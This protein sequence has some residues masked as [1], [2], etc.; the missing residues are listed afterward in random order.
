[1][2]LWLPRWPID[3]RRHTL[4][5]RRDKPGP[6]VLAA[7]VGN[8][9]LVTAVNAAAEALGIAPGL[10]LA[11]AR[12]LHPALAVA[13][14]DPAGD[15][16]ALARLALWCGRYS[17]WTAPHG[18]DGVWLDVTG[19]AHLQGGEESLAAELVERLGRQGIAGRAAIAD[20]AGAA[21]AVA[22]CGSAPAVVV[23]E[24]GM[25]AA[26]A[27][28]PVLAL[29]LDPALAGELER[30]GLRRIGDLY[31]LPR[32]ALVTR[33][34][35]QVTRRLDQALGAVP[36]PLSPLPP[37][38]ARWTRRRFAEPIG[39][40]EAIAAATRALLEALCRRL[41]DEG[42]GLR[43][44]K[45]KLYRVDGS[46][47]EAAIGTARPSR[48]VRH[49]LRLIEEKL[50]AID[51]GL[52]IEDML[53]EAAK[54]ETLAAA[55]LSFRNA[56][57]PFTVIPAKAGTQGNRTSLALGPRFRG[58]DGRK[59]RGEERGY[60]R[61]DETEIAALVDRLA[62][63]LGPGAVF[64][65]LPRESHVPERAVRRAPVFTTTKAAPWD[66]QRLRP[67][68]LLPRPEPIEAVA[69]I[70]DD[71]PILFRWR[72]LQH[73][74]RRA[75]GPERILGEWWRSAEEAEELRDYYR[76]E[77]EAG[78]RFWLYRLGLYRPEAPPRWFLHGLFV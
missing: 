55:Q 78:R 5:P 14:A 39:T 49:L 63:R 53:L 61:V 25:R 7:A 9:R 74:I 8:R 32:A 26:L 21:W 3:R 13:A 23:P 41:A 71:P 12:A 72:R 4:G 38:P 75:D 29:R 24:G 62:N 44:L 43:R 18:S 10:A 33:F 54:V 60:E 67:I 35:E 77:D 47:A 6:L 30:L 48:D 73:Q 46:S 58:D 15:A 42:L 76:V 56:L 22:C 37:A 50:I 64:A 20:T 65:I 52:G 34:G 45:L 70:P 66:P 36:E 17:P 68:R 27:P 11:D 40:A 2:S 28:L 51:P 19:C 31:A 69:P 57:N 1:M 59:N 16:A